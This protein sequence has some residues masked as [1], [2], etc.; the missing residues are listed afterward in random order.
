MHRQASGC[1][2]ASPGTVA[3]CYFLPKKPFRLAVICVRTSCQDTGLHPFL[4]SKVA[5]LVMS[6]TCHVCTSSSGANVDQET[7]RGT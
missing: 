6:G 4:S 5:S 7:G 1:G 2:A 3:I